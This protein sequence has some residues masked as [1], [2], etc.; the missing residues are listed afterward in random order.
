MDKIIER[1]EIKTISTPEKKVV[2]PVKTIKAQITGRKPGPKSSK[3][4]QIL[5]MLQI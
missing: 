1:K 5:I 4:S 3:F 2:T